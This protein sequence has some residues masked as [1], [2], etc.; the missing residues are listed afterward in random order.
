M[1]RGILHLGQ[2][3]DATTRLFRAKPLRNMTAEFLQADA[4]Y[5]LRH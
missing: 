4:K 1:Q 2:F 5:L 3:G